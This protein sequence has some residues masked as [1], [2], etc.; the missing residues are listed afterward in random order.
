MHSARTGELLYTTSFSTLF[1]EWISTE[2]AKHTARSFEN[3]FLLPMPR[4]SVRLTVTLCDL[5]GE[6]TATFSHVVHPSDILISTLP[7]S[8]APRRYLRRAANPG[9]AIN[10][11]IVAEGYTAGEAEQ[12]FRDAAA[13]DSALFAH[14]AFREMADRFNVVAVAL[15][16]AESGVSVPRQNIWRQ[17][18]LGSHFDTFYS[19][20]YLTTKNLRTLHTALTG[21]PYEHIIVLANTPVYGGGGIYNAYT[22]TTAGHAAFHPVVVH[23]FGHSFAGLADEYFYE[24]DAYGDF[25]F[26]GIEPWEQNITTLTDFS[27]K[28][29]SLLPAGEVQVQDAAAVP[30]GAAGLVEGGGYRAKGVY[31]CAADCRM[32][33]NEA[34]DF[35]PACSLALTRIIRFYTE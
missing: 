8:T 27:G 21:I 6:P 24:G 10:V 30:E 5:R 22:L 35:C 14:S 33:S 28:W 4:D 9:R 17:T 13:A 31:R 29:R 15:P 34:R 7:A 11:A 20:R 25:Y 19:E 18:P 32:R 3:V 16:S 23:E 1:Q 12:F 2:E 26:P